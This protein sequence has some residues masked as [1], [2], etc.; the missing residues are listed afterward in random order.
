VVLDSKQSAHSLDRGFNFYDN[1]PE[2]VKS[3]SRWG[4]IER[5]GMDVA[6]RTERWLNAQRTGPYFV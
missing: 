2:H 4:R 5:R 6:Q 3:K 1:L